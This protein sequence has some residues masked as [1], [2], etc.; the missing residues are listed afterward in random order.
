[1]K[2]RKQTYSL[3]QYLKLI[4]SETIRTDQECQRLSGQ[5][6]ANM[7]N[8]LLYTVLTDGYIP[9][10]ILGE[11]ITGEITRQW[12]IDGLQRSSSLSLFRYA[13]TKITKNIDEYMVTYQ[14]RVTDENG[15]VKRD[16]MGEI[17]W[18]SVDYDIRNKTYDQL[19]EELRDRFNGYQIELAIHQNCDATEIS[20]L[21]RRFNNHTAMNTAQKAFTYVDEFASEIRNIAENR[22]FLD[23][24]TCSR[25]DKKNGTIERVIGETALLCNYPD[26]YRKDT[27]VNFK[28]LNENAS[29]SDFDNLNN[30]FTRLTDSINTTKEIK[31]LF[32]SKNAHIFLTAFN[33]F[34][35]LG[36]KDEEFGRFLD[37][38]V[39]G[40]NETV[41]NG[42]SWEMWDANKSTRDSSVV[43]GKIDYLVELINQY[44]A[45]NRKAVGKF[46]MI[47]GNQYWKN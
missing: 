39:N 12:I 35:Q 43:H 10:I 28:A 14:R 36:Q 32:N 17:V 24:Y 27:K 7:V 8:E 3:D 38:F 40:G 42:K 29:L 33:V 22:F 46:C 2:I 9:P 45:E 41:I 26:L 4:Q 16:A 20:K 5:W 21:V 47:G 30:L 31:S 44:F 19:P 13:N 25:N 11:E 23:V 34:T 37:W 6:N 18:E 15:N 1:M